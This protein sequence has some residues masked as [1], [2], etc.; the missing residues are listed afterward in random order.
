MAPIIM[1][2]GFGGM[3][4]IRVF[5][6]WIEHHSLRLYN[7]RHPS[8]VLKSNSI[9]T[10]LISKQFQASKSIF[11]S[12]CFSF[13][14]TH[15]PPSQKHF[16]KKP[17]ARTPLP[18]PQWSADFRLF[19]KAVSLPVY[20]FLSHDSL[21]RMKKRLP[22]T[23]TSN[24]LPP[25]FTNPKAF[26]ENHLLLYHQSQGWRQRVHSQQFHL[27]IYHLFDQEQVLA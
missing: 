26:Q 12:S 6:E 23:E 16:T 17:T 21:T 11:P 2:I 25:L 4:Y 10:Q 19:L 3:E 20:Y 15:S 27:R 7:I 8:D 1:A 9:S 18:R 24:A 14:F 5:S 13:F 22:R